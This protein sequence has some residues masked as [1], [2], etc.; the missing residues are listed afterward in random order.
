[1]RT[2]KITSMSLSLLI[3]A[4]IVNSIACTNLSPKARHGTHWNRIGKRERG[5]SYLMAQIDPDTN[6]QEETLLNNYDDI[7]QN[8]TTDDS[9][10]N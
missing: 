4:L 6:N 9:Y 10:G 1:M 8:D 7:I 5:S 2:D 3:F